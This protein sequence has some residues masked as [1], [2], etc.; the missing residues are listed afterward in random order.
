MVA[1]NKTYRKTLTPDRSAK[2]SGR[3][4]YSA[5]ISR[6]LSR[7]PIGE[8]GGF[9]L[10]VM[11]ANNP[12]VMADLLGLG[13][14]KTKATWKTVAFEFELSVNMQFTG[15]FQ[16]TET[17]SSGSMVFNSAN[18][19]A[20]IL[21]GHLRFSLEQH[22]DGTG[23]LVGEADVKARFAS[24]WAPGVRLRRFSGTLEASIENDTQCG[25]ICRARL[26]GRPRSPLVWILVP[27]ISGSGEAS[28]PKSCSQLGVIERAELIRDATQSLKFR[29]ILL[30]VIPWPWSFSAPAQEGGITLPDLSG[31]FH[32]EIEYSP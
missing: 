19:G 14:L 10:Y 12:I 5:E 32:I 7:D 15:F 31:D 30:G 24:W 9:N 11:A 28:S 25:C 17:S 22:T 27:T 3:R 4:F 16:E 29:P 13:T 8:A 1:L 2:D 26:S 23:S 6:W 18:F 21:D 20:A